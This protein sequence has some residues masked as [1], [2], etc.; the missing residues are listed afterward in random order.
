MAPPNFWA[1]GKQSTKIS[2]IMVKK[3]KDRIQILA[4]PRPSN[5]RPDLT[6]SPTAPVHPTPTPPP[7]KG[8]PR[9]M[10]NLV[11]R[12]YRAGPAERLGLL[13]S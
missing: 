8:E 10:A 1:D 11:D 3:K 6:L 13:A 7:P 12:A 5:P 4:H 9:N 2:H